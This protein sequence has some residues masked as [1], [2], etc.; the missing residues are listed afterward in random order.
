MKHLWP[1]LAIFLILVAVYYRV[2]IFRVGSF[3]VD[4]FGV[5]VKETPVVKIG[6][7]VVTRE[8]VARRGRVLKIMDA[9]REPTEAE[10]L[11]NLS[12]LILSFEILKVERGPPDRNSLVLEYGEM[13]RKTREADKLEQVRKIFDTEDEFLFEYVGP[14]IASQNIYFGIYKERGDKDNT[15]FDEFMRSKAHQIPIQAFERETWSN[16]LKNL[17]WLR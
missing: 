9:V 10:S 1:F 5:D 12:K 13:R 4:I 6:G 2:Q 15:T 7:T 17:S 11:T 16:A 3:G 14:M 8:M